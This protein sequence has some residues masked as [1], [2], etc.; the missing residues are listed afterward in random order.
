M[1]CGPYY[2]LRE[3]YHDLTFVIFCSLA[4]VYSSDGVVTFSDQVAQGVQSHYCILRDIA[5]LPL[6]IGGLVCIATTHS[7]GLCQLPCAA[8]SQLMLILVA[9]Q[10]RCIS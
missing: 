8:A 9:M 10:D 5:I 4:A 3:K 7:P 2:H 1:V 6:G